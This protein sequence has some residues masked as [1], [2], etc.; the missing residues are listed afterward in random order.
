MMEQF[1]GEKD[2]N[3]STPGK[4][5]AGI[6][7]SS[8]SVEDLRRIN[9]IEILIKNTNK[10]SFPKIDRL[11]FN[12]A[13]YHGKF[14]LIPLFNLTVD[15]ADTY[16]VSCYYP[17]NQGPDIQI[18]FIGSNARYAQMEIIIS[19]FLSIIFICISLYLI[20][21]RFKDRMKF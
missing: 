7:S 3:F 14:G 4:Y 16:K 8:Y 11:P 6:F 19:F 10:D 5:V 9:D 2:L 20:V 13:E 18:M 1:P 17:S 21:K 15:Y 12:P